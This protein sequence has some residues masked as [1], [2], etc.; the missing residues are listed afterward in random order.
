MPVHTQPAEQRGFALLCNLS[1]LTVQRRDSRR[2]SF[3]VTCVIK[4]NSDRPGVSDVQ[5]WFAPATGDRIYTLDDAEQAELSASGDWQDE[6]R[7]FGAFDRAWLGS[8]PV[9]RF[10]NTNTGWHLFTS[11]LNQG[12][13][14]DGIAYEG[15]GWHASQFTPAP[16]EIRFDR[17]DDVVLTDPILSGPRRFRFAPI[18]PTEPR[19]GRRWLQ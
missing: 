16:A 11:D 10:F 12:L 3:I 4:G 6:G 2:I 14:Q 1:T 19:G 8:A 13:Q 5:A 15:I 17:S 9:Y 7:A 18:H